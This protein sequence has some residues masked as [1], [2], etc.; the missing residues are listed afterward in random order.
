MGGGLGLRFRLV[1]GMG[2]LSIPARQPPGPADE[3]WR[4][5]CF[6][7]FIARDDG[8]GYREFNF[9]PSGLWAVYDFSDYR[10]RVSGF[11]PGAEP[12]IVV[13]RTDEGLELEARLPAA[14][15]PGGRRLGLT[16]VV[17]AKDGSLSYWALAH[18]SEKPDFHHPG[19]LVL[20]LP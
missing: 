20:S 9:S 17:E 1:G 4:H 11:R 8:P 10:Q 19:G 14:L 15:L 13:K 3:L 16:A 6:E 7:C 12:V 2:A 5:T 18:P